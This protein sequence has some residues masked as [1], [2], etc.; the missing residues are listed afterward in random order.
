MSVDIW[1]KPGLGITHVPVIIPEKLGLVVI[2][3]FETAFGRSTSEE[4]RH[5]WP[6]KLELVEKHV[7]GDE[8]RYLSAYVRIVQ[9]ERLQYMCVNARFP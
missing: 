8:I 5:I 3:D 4:W 7:T 2:N 1:A 6:L 9:N